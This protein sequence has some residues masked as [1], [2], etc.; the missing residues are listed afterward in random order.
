MILTDKDENLLDNDTFEFTV[1]GTSLATKRGDRRLKR[2]LRNPEVQVVDVDGWT[3][4][5]VPEKG[6]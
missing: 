2:L 6:R 5:A 3:V 1:S 4:M